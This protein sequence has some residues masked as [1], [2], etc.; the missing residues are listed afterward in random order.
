MPEKLP[1]FLKP[2]EQLPRSKRGKNSFYDEIIREFV[3]SSFK[4]AEV[5]D[6]GRNPSTVQIMLKS[7][8]KKRREKV[9]VLIRN[10]R[11]YLERIDDPRN[12]LGATTGRN[13]KRIH[14]EPELKRQ[15][16]NETRPS[17]DVITLLNTAIVKARCP[18][19]RMLNAKDSRECIECGHRFYGNEEEYRESLKSMEELERKLNAGK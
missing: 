16:N 12:K 7:R 8:L 1:K 10:K 14:S 11:V 3:F 4:C 2:V 5:K 19:C 18:K 6:L 9:R 13:L 15:A 17:V